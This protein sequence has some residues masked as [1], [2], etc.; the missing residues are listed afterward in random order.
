[1]LV[2]G[3]LVNGWFDQAATAYSADVAMPNGQ[4]TVLVEFF[5][6]VGAPVAWFSQT[7]I[8]DG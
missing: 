8:A 7:R 2:D 5:E 6:H 4:H 3:A 1:V